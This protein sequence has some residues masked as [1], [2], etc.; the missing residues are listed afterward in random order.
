MCHSVHVI[1]DVLV[2]MVPYGGM[3][4][5]QRRWLQDSV[6]IPLLFFL[7]SSSHTY[8]RARDTRGDL[9]AEN[10]C[11]AARRWRNSYDAGKV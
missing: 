3:T 4:G 1:G 8:T 5:W 10:F 6:A 11:Q 2:A 7:L 9:A